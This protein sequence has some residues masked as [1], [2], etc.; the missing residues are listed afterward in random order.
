[1]LRVRLLGLL[2]VLYTASAALA[3]TGTFAPVQDTYL[4]SFNTSSNYGTATSRCTG[5]CC[6]SISAP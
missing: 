4:D 1:M 5:R 2:V 6:V 3:A